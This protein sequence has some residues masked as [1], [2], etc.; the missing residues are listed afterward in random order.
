M[1]DNQA[2][3]SDGTFDRTRVASGCWD[4][5]VTDERWR[6]NSSIRFQMIRACAFG[7]VSD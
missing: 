6:Q 4:G 3:G 2:R 7:A 5:L 1:S